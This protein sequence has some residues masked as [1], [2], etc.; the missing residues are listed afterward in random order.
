MKV[1]TQAAEKAERTKSLRGRVAGSRRQASKIGNTLYWKDLLQDD[2]P[3]VKLIKDQNQKL[4]ERIA[5]LEFASATF[6][7]AVSKTPVIMSTPKSRNTA[8][9]KELLM[10]L[11]E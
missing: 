6:K 5:Q 4:R 7:D 11:R 10:T 9:T 2:S 8:G 1:A 3:N